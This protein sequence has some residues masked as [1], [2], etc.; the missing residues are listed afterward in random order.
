[1]PDNSS[2]GKIK[3]LHHLQLLQ[4]KPTTRSQK[5]QNLLALKA[6]APKPAK[7]LAAKGVSVI[8]AG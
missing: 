6:L 8:P 3:F 2:L 7:L 4:P 5:Q 1:L